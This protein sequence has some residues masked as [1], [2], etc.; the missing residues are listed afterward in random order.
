MDNEWENRERTGSVIFF[1]FY[2][3][4]TPHGQCNRYN[5]RLKLHLIHQ[6]TFEFLALYNLSANQ[7][8]GEKRLPR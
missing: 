7:L 6:I 3:S 8:D 5:R 1:S 4:Q 2:R